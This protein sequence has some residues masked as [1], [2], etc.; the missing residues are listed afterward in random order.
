MPLR[1]TSFDEAWR[2]FEA[3]GALVPIA[4]QREHLLG[5]RA[6]FLV[7]H[8]RMTDPRI[9]DAAAD[10]LEELSDVAG[11]VPMDLDHLHV[12]I[13]AVGFQVIERRRDDEVL[14]QEVGGISERAARIAKRAKPARV[15]VGPVN[16]FP[17]ALI[18]EVHDDAGALSSLRREL[19]TA[20]GGDAF[21]LDDAQYLPHVTIA[22][23]ESAEAGDALRER[24]PSLRAQF[25]P[26]EAL[27]RR[28]EL[29]RWWFTGLDDASEP[30]LDVVR[31][32][33]LRG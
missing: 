23:F 16:V 6:Q 12:S 30:E 15:E 29:A 19:A 1:F 20:T 5:G 18:L 25:D 2:W 26:V 9:A 3:G 17:D 27:V 8:A 32:Y 21:G 24:L 13:R 7:F 33:A 11:L 4:E 10:V 14:R 31:E 22:W 28:F